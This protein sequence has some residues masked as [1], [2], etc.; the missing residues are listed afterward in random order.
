MSVL[1]LIPGGAAADIPE[2]NWYLIYPDSGDID[3]AHTEWLRLVADMRA[4]STY[5]LANHHSMERLV[6]TRVI[7]NRSLRVVEEDGAVLI[8][9]STCNVVQNKH[10]AIVRQSDAMIRALE[11]ELCISP[12]RRG[13]AG[14]IKSAGGAGAADRYLSRAG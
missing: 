8:S 4:M 12:Y 13:K 1:Q 3:F 10:W 11:A 2:P 14:K 6:R 9:S 5:S 7:L